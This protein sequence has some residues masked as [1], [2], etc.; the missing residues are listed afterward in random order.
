MSIRLVK[1]ADSWFV[2]KLI[3]VEPTKN[4]LRRVDYFLYEGC[5]NLYRS[6]KNYE[7]LQI[8]SSRE[9]W[10]AQDLSQKGNS[11]NCF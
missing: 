11:P 4:H 3:Q 7:S 8:K 5:S 10:D 9:T 2:A 1:L 6:L